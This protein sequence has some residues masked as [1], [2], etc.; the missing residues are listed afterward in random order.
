MLLLAIAFT[1]DVQHLFC[2]RD[3]YFW[4]LCL[5]AAPALDVDW[6]NTDSFASCSTDQSIHVCRLGQHRPIKTF[7]GH[8]VG[9][10]T[11]C[12][13]NFVQTGRSRTKNVRNLLPQ[14]YSSPLSSKSFT[15]LC[16][17]W[18]PGFKGFRASKRKCGTIRI[19]GDFFFSVSL[20]WEVQSSC[21]HSPARAPSKSAVNFP[22][23]PPLL[24]LVLYFPE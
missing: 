8:T 9:H 14:F 3:I 12:H 6:Q 22:P 1:S 20:S 7:Q 13:I 11:L 4:F 24:K 23:Y 16:C 18:H 17:S 5:V 21:G 15:F 2:M 10:T 19:Y